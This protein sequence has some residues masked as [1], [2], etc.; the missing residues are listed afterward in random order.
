MIDWEYE[1]S[2]CAFPTKDEKSRGADSQD[3]P[4]PGTASQ[5]VA[6][7][8]PTPEYGSLEWVMSIAA[9][10]AALDAELTALDRTVTEFTNRAVNSHHELLAALKGIHEHCPCDPDIN[11]RWLAAWDAMHAAIT[12]AEGR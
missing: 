2:R 8:D 5:G 12:R 3:P 10:R 1:R 6:G 11:P 7:S 4:S 9:R